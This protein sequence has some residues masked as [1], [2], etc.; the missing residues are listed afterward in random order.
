MTDMGGMEKFKDILSEALAKNLDQVMIEVG[1]KIIGNA[2]GKT[3]L[4][5]IAPVEQAWII[6]IARHLLPNQASQVE[7]GHTI[8]GVINAG[9]PGRIGVVIQPQKL[10][11][12]MGPA[13]EKQAHMLFEI[14]ATTAQFAMKPKTEPISFNT[15]PLN[16]ASGV[17]IPPPPTSQAP[18][19]FTGLLEQTPDIEANIDNFEVTVPAS[20]LESAI[21]YPSEDKEDDDFPSFDN[22]NDNFGSIELNLAP[23]KAI[24]AELEDLPIAPYSLPEEDL[25]EAENLDLLLQDMTKQGASDLILIPGESPL[26][27]INGS[28]TKSQESALKK[29]TIEDWFNSIV[30]ALTKR[31]LHEQG[32]ATFSFSI[33]SGERLRCAITQGVKGYTTSLR[34]IPEKAATISDLAMP[35]IFSKI[36]SLTKGLVIVGGTR[37]M[38]KSWT[39]AA[40]LSAMAQDQAAH[41][42]TI[43]EPIEHFIRSSKGLVTQIELGLHCESFSQVIEGMSTQN[44][45]IICLGDLKNAER[46]RAALELADCGYLVLATLNT[47]SINAGLHRLMDYF[48]LE[49]HPS[50]RALL[51][52]HLR[53]MACQT[54]CR[55]QSATRTAAFEI[56]VNS[57]GLTTLLKENRLA[58]LNNYL[59]TQ[60]ALG[61]VPLNESLL[62]LVANQTVSI[63]EAWIHAYDKKDFEEAAKRRRI[64][65]KVS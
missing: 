9:K 29:E 51:A 54:L 15:I 34:L 35:E 59:Q 17:N 6:Q 4:L 26:F 27:R 65:P 37:G 31:K 33:P 55:N 39:M 43:E 36:A 28:L 40:L 7:H 56:L 11:V 42:L 24:Q 12:F 5:T 10:T 3:H 45:D 8:Q 22:A 63:Q 25:P 41:I 20:H 64:L 1:K 60:Q 18:Q 38:G 32:H 16:L 19:S 48:A 2:Q 49:Q 21:S 46:F 13:A 23:Q 58:M 61:N 62:N 50:V 30:S 52:T 44:V 53:V 57:E 47:V 14:L